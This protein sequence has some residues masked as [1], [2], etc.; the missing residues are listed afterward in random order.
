MA[1]GVSVV[2]VVSVVS[3]AIATPHS[4][5]FLLPIPDSLLP[6]PDSLKPR[7]LSPNLN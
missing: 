5:P 2:S 1:R 3:L 4:P 7:K 6:T